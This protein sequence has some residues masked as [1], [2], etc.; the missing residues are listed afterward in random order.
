MSKKILGLGFAVLIL[1]SVAVVSAHTFGFD[2]GYLNYELD[3]DISYDEVDEVYVVDA[4]FVFCRNGFGYLGHPALRDNSW[5]AGSVDECCSYGI[6]ESTGACHTAPIGLSGYSCSVFGTCSTV[7]G[8]YRGYENAYYDIV[9]EYVESHDACSAYN[10]PDAWVG[11][12]TFETDSLEDYV[13]SSGMGYFINGDLAGLAVPIYVAPEY[14][15]PIEEEEICDDDLDNDGDGLVDCEDDDCNDADNCKED[16]VPCC[17]DEDCDFLDYLTGLYCLDGNVVITSHD[18]SCSILGLCEEEVLTTVVEEC[19][20]GCE[21][22]ACL[23]EPIVDPE[24][25]EATVVE[26]CGDGYV[27]APYCEAGNV[28]A[29]GSSFSCVEGECVENETFTIIES[30]EYG[31]E[32]GSCL[33]EEED[34]DDDDC[35]DDRRKKKE[36]TDDDLT[37]ITGDVGGTE[38]FETLTLSVAKNGEGKDSGWRFWLW[39]LIILAILILVLVILILFANSN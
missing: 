23:D 14:E 38:V 34:D 15:E 19:E 2:T 1:V 28:V 37:V 31:C 4:E 32:D 3:Y 26:D 10:Y 18:F 11:R 5:C 6:D 9:P 35:D 8:N 12:Q 24:C 29:R 25:T 20:Y 17:T 30:C 22:S 13:V 21:N 39:L 36:R 33:E 16:P 7:L 27:T